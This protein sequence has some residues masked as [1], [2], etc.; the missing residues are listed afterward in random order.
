M[1]EDG[2]HG[3]L[4]RIEIGRIIWP[5]RSVSILKV[6]AEKKDVKEVQ[7]ALPVGIEWWY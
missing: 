2:D 7:K 4:K 5:S 1:E 3:E 6:Q